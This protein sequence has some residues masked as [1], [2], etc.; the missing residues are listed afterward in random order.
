MPRDN[1]L[2][3]LVQDNSVNLNEFPALDNLYKVDENAQLTLGDLHGNAKKLLYTLVRH[4]VVRN[5]KRDDYAQ[6]VQLYNKNNNDISLEDLR[7]FDDFLDKIEIN[8]QGTI[9][10][11]GD[12]LADRGSND[13]FTLRLLAK[14]AQNTNLAILVSNH[15]LEFIRAYEK[16]T[17][18][19]SENLL[20]GQAASMENLQTLIN[21]GLVN[22]PDVEQIVSNLYLPKVKL[23]DYTIDEAN[24][25][26]AIFSHAPIGI[27]S[28]EY[29]AQKLGVTYKDDTLT[30][31]AQTIEDIN[32]AF[33]NNY[34]N[35][36]QIHT[37]FDNEQC[38]GDPA[39]A[40]PK[41]APFLHLI[42]NRNHQLN[43]PENYKGY[44][45]KFIHGHDIKPSTIAHR[46]YNLDNVLGKG[47]AAQGPYH[48]HFT[49]EKALL[50]HNNAQSS[51]ED[52]VL[53]AQPS[54]KDRIILGLKNFLWRPSRYPGFVGLFATALVASG[55][56]ILGFSA[57]TFAIA[58]VITFTFTVN[59]TRLRNH[60]AY[61]ALR[62]V[63]ENTVAQQSQ[64]TRNAFTLGQEAAKGWLPYAKSF[65]LLNTAP[66]KDY[67]AFAAGMKSELDKTSQRTTPA[68]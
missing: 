67:G 54:R 49:H 2:N 5:L 12:E 10:L 55:A 50:K 43:R 57:F 41:I 29:I 27:E 13:Y 34:V 6:F 28:I 14:L 4:D 48:V 24:Q 60:I 25:R 58:S 47:S 68:I 26:L 3:S 38:I 7:W 37:L 39:Y 63:N 31:L 30:E 51:S 52:I 42:W 36:K 20:W 59:F 22:K 33:T 66:W 53:P 45:L 8:P 1:A 44:K 9:R 19:I 64:T 16:G 32:T 11:I 21:K 35:T 17:P 56:S 40:D 15:S 62:S 23:L 18:Y 46:I 61:N 65:N